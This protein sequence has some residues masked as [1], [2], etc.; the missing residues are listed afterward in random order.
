MSATSRM[1]SA[2]ATDEPPNCSTAEQQQSRHYQCELG[3]CTFSD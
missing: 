3:W 2:V 1:R